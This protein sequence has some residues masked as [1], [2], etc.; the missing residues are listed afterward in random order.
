MKNI[1]NYLSL[2][3]GLRALAFT[4]LIYLVTVQVNE[5]LSYPAQ[6]THFKER[7]ALVS[8]SPS[9]GP[10]SHYLMEITDTQF[11]PGSAQK[12]ALI[13]IRT[14]TTPV[15][16]YQLVC[17]HNHS[18]QI[19]VRAVSPWGRS[20]PYSEDSILFI[21]DQKK[22]EITISYPSSF[23]NTQSPFLALAG[24]YEDPNLDS[25]TVNGVTATVNAAEHQFN[26]SIELTEGLNSIALH[27][28]D[29]AGNI[30]SK[31]LEIAYTPLSATSDN[32]AP[33]EID[34]NHDGNRDI[35]V[36]TAE[37]KIALFINAGTDTDPVFSHYDFLTADGHIIDVGTH[38]SPF[39]ADLNNDGM[40]DLVAG[41]GEGTLLYFENRGST[42]Y[43]AFAPPTLLHDVE[44]SALG[45]RSFCSPCVVDWDD[46][47][48]K[49]ILLGNGNGDLVLYRNEGNEDEPL[50]APQVKVE[51]D[52]AAINV[53]SS[54]VP[55]VSDWDGDGGKDLL[56]KNEKGQL[57]LFLNAVLHG[58]PDL[59]PAEAFQV[60][61]LRL[62]SSGFP[63]SIPFNWN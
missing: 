38:A 7:R 39:I 32:L 36:G 34:Y 49:D 31:R 25:I 12:N 47:S 60:E 18:Y 2:W 15:P 57:F 5:A 48:R 26:A 4:L 58:E 40:G 44:G 17:E 16:L 11:F 45:V 35:L 6:A 22:P 51:V 54:A 30:T 56:V 28:W 27:A 37:G 62:P 43:Y 20:S 9:S 41:N 42:N 3:N 21:C 52:D 1:L 29:L 59:F 10:V 33:F 19:R 24:S 50:F 55:R 8:W 13:R 46:D 53:E 61:N 23:T 14:A 63:V